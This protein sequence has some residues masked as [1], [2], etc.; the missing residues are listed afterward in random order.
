MNW[1]EALN[2]DHASASG[3]SD[4]ERQA[5]DVKIAAHAEKPEELRQSL[6][7]LYLLVTSIKDYAIFMLDPA[8]HVVTWNAGAQHLKGY[9]EEEILGKDFSLFYTPE[10]VASGRPPCGLGVAARDGRY[11]DEGWRVR[12]DGT[13]FWADVVITALR[14]TEGRLVGFGKVTRDLTERKQAEEERLRF[15]RER[16]A[17]GAAEWS[18]H[19]RDE[20]LSIAAHELKTPVTSLRLQAQILFR[21]LGAMGV[22]DPV[23]LRRALGLIVNQSQKL[24]DLVNRLFDVSR[25][26][27]GRL[28]LDRV[29]ADVVPI[30]AGVVDAK[31][32]LA[33]SLPIVVETPAQL[34]ASIDPLRLEQV[35]TNLL[36]NAVRY[37]AVGRIDVIVARREPDRLE[38]SVRDHG[39]GIPTERRDHIFDRFN[40]A[41]DRRDESGL[42]LGLYLSQQI[43]RLHG[44]EIHAEYPPDG[45]TRFVVALPI[46]GEELGES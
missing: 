22:I 10:D 44:G 23:Q 5:L 11:E 1:P 30:V 40:H 26:T 42:G 31:R 33:G 6:E 37:G 4:A 41:N 19:L 46:R 25:I 29:E 43:V 18:V 12:K 39:P 34:V 14:D 35:V 21:Q 17:R 20:F 38:I 24:A 13:R 9:S 7:R 16:E 8:G 15:I 2:T 27:N 32:L 28:A 36:D 45:G 3:D